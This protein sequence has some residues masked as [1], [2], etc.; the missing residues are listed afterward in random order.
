MKKLKPN[1]AVCLLAAVLV[2]LLP[3]AGSVRGA[4]A[5]IPTL[6]HN[7]DP[8]YKDGV[9]P[10][11][12]RDDV[13]YIPA[14][15]FTMFDYMR[16]STPTADNL[17]IHNT[18]TGAYVSILFLEQSALINGELYENIGV[19]RDGGVYYVEADTV[20][21]GL[22]FTTRLYIREK[23]D[24]TMQI[25]DSNVISTSL[26]AL[27]RSYLPDDGGDEYTGENLPADTVPDGSAE[28]DTASRVIYLFCGEPDPTDEFRAK[29][30]LDEEKLNYT[31]FLNADSDPGT[32]IRQNI[33]GICGLALPD[34]VRDGDIAGTMNGINRRFMQITRSRVTLTLSTGDET[35]DESLKNAGYCPVTPDFEVNGGSDPDSLIVSILGT[36][37]EKGWCTVWMDDCWNT[38]E[39]ARKLADL[40]ETEYKTANYAYRAPDRSGSSR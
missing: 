5:E 27:I 32:L 15:I 34:L 37:D 36:A 21:E 40:D 26:T 31:L 13:R 38:V 14:E 28:E 1:K 24:I 10:M 12:E 2:I 39:I 17:L 25:C 9:S 29:K 4:E 18:E 33:G 19:F 22:G 6:F 16:V 35:W 11:V 23:G 20:C 7:D 8:W 30:V 3:C